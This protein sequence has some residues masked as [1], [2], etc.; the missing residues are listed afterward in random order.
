MPCLGMT[1]MITSYFHVDPSNW[2]NKRQVE[3][4]SAPNS[5]LVR[6]CVSP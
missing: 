5:R 1:R 2:S 4:Q 3:S 6:L